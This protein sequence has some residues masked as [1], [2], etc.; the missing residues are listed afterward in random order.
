MKKNTLLSDITKA[1]KGLPFI[2]HTSSQ[3]KQP[4]IHHDFSAAWD[5]SVPDSLQVSQQNGILTMVLNRPEVLNAIDI[6][7]AE[8]LLQ[9]LEAAAVDPGIR[10]IIITGAGRAFCAGGDLKFAVQANPDQPGDSFLILTTILHDSIETIR[11]M[12]KPVVAAIN[13][14]AAGAGLF[15]ALACDMRMMA[16]TAYLKQSNTS[17]GLSLPAGGTF[18]LPRLVGLGRAL[19]MVML[20]RSIPAEEAQRVGLVT[21]VVK[22]GK[23]YAEAQT[24]AQQAAQMPIS[25]LGRVKRLMNE[26]FDR[27]LAE[28]LAAEQQAIVRSA[29]SAEGREGL[30]AF[31]QKRKPAYVNLSA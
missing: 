14:P 18:S 26:S 31:L 7:M 12:A 16:H 11:T 1:F 9:H 6:D 19:E 25:T 13:G 24:L 17:Y 3:A 27:S 8:A 22:A 10:A 29:N 23:L 30:T 2:K 28:Q 4:A 21:T 5:L 15:L 20:D